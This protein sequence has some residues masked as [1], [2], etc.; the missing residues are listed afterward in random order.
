M[1]QILEQ[2]NAICDRLDAALRDILSTLESPATRQTAEQLAS[3]ENAVES[4]DSK[5]VPVPEQLQDLL[6]SLREQVRKTGESRD[7]LDAVRQRLQTWTDLISSQGDEHPVRS[8]D[9]RKPGIREED[10]EPLI[11]E[12]LTEAGGAARADDVL[13]VVEERLGSS[14][15]EADLQPGPNG[16]PRWHATAEWAHQNLLDRGVA[17]IGDQAGVWQLSPQ[18]ARKSA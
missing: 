1:S 13:A 8:K 2:V 14:L 6:N 11:V 3:V 9:P 16:R 17:E 10:L 5:G 7:A 4:L 18:Y 15:G 12:A